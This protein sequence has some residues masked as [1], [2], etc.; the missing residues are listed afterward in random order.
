MIS[1]ENDHEEVDDDNLQLGE[2]ESFEHD[3]R[4]LITSLKKLVSIDTDFLFRTQGA[5]DA[6]WAT[7]KALDQ[8]EPWLDVEESPEQMGWVGK[9]GQP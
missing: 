2:D 4:D 8:F 9:N 6:W 3:L 1:K 7:R 5:Y